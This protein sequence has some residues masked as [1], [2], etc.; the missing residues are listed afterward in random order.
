MFV[1]DKLEL[2]GSLKP[3]FKRQRCIEPKIMEKV[4][5]I[6][7]RYSSYISISRAWH[8][9]SRLALVVVESSKIQLKDGIFSE[10]IHLPTNKPNKFRLVNPLVF[11]PY[12]NTRR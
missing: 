12:I 4:F 8:F 3:V 11:F 7:N 1:W 9:I 6:N 2:F 5:I 10:T